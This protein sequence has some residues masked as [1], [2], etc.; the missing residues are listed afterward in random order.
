LE[1]VR[2]D[3][4]G[5]CISNLV[6]ALRGRESWVPETVR[7]A[8]SVVLLLVDGLG[9]NLVHE[10]RAFAPTITSLEGGS[11]TTVVPSTTTAAL[12]SVTT[13]LSPAE[14]GI[15]GYRLLVEREVLNVLRW[16]LPWGRRPPNPGE[17]QPRLA[18]GGEPIPVVTRA[19]FEATGF[20]NVH[21][22]GARFCGWHSVSS[23]G[24]HCRRL[25]DEGDKFVYAYYG[26]ADIVFHMQGLDDEFL[27]AE[28]G[29]VDRLVA[30]V[31]ESI[32]DSSALV[33]T[34]DHGH[35]QFDRWIEL[36]AIDSLIEAQAGEARF[37]YLHAHQGA[38]DEL[39]AAATELCAK[40]AWVFSRDQLV[41]EGW[42]GGRAPSADVRRR[43]GDVVL[44][45]RGPVGFT[46]PAN[47]GEARLRS[48]HGSLTPDE[49]LVP[50]IAGRGR[51]GARGAQRP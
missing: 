3:Y 31:L 43:L 36:T 2:P 15:V 30:D 7:D 14:H 24:V 46:D 35:V 49:M 29:F 37:R 27:T 11:I 20:T 16:S 50:L 45:A 8:A 33:V 22:R 10:H 13:G 6:R 25:L 47:A 26:N 39:L 32:P 51:S 40:D 44:A 1:P 9:W 17:F 34:A 19:E 18:F 41:D 23:I 5:A 12:T 38:A 48:G 21:L 28:V 4:E 42:V